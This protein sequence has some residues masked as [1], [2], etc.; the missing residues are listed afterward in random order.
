VRLAVSYPGKDMQFMSFPFK[1]RCQLGDVSG[2]AA[3]G[4]RMK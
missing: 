2:N 4:D 3:N 1:C